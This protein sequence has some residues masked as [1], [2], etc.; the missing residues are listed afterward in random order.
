MISPRTSVVVDD[1]HVLGVAILPDET[2]PVLIVDPDAVL[3]T[4]VPGQRFQ[5]IAGKRRQIANLSGGQPF[6]RSSRK[7][8]PTR[9]QK[10]TEIA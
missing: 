8:P 1:L 6:D 2:D 4:P 3:T 9:A 7:L 10:M 5:P